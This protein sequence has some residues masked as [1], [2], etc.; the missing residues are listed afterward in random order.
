MPLA[1]RLLALISIAVVT[2]LG[3]YAARPWGDNYAYKTL[4]DYL[5]L[6]VFLAWA[7]SPYA[8]FA[9]KAQATGS[10]HTARFV[11]ALIVCGAGIAAVTDSIFIH[12]DAQG[13]LV[14]LFLPVY[15]WAGIGMFSI[16]CW[17]LG[18]RTRT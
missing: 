8:F 15:Q 14:F 11:A 18:R 3:I 1:T 2:V 4:A 5:V 6:L 9:R 7:A 16:L 10:C 13:G 17:L 12:P